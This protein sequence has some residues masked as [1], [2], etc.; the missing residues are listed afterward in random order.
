MKKSNE[1]QITTK[2]TT[3]S[4]LF[5]KES[6]LFEISRPHSKT[7]TFSSRT[8]NKQNIINLFGSDFV[9]INQDFTFKPNSAPFDDVCSMCSSR[10]YFKKF[11]CVLCPNCVLCEKCEDEH[12]HPLILK[13]IKI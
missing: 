2:K 10:I 6:D 1:N 12:L 3:S 8:T 7:L 11:I 13:N 4:D 9:N 5:D